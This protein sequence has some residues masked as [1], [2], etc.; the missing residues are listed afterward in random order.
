MRK[1]RKS[2][3]THKHTHTHKISVN[4]IEKSHS[5]ICNP[6][7]EANE[8]RRMLIET[9]RVSIETTARQASVFG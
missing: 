3:V 2:A 4:M 5:R 1:H 9:M 6:K 7:H 8:T